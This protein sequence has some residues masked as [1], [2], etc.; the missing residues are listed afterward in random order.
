MEIAREPASAH[1]LRVDLLAVPLHGGARPG[2]DLAALDAATSGRLLRELKQRTA[3]PAKRG[4]V[5]IYQTHGALPADLIA[6]IGVGGGKKGEALTLEDWRRFAGQAVG[7]AQASRARSLAISV[8]SA[9]KV[10]RASCRE[11]VYGTV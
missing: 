5:G 9:P 2:T 3:D 8:A 6:V 10:G 11:R 1:R 7:A 4:A